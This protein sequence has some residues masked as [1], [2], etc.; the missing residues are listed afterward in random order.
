MSISFRSLF[1][2]H[3]LFI[4]KSLKELYSYINK[5]ITS[6]FS[7]SIYLPST[8]HIYVLKFDITHHMHQVTCR[9]RSMVIALLATVLC[10]FFFPLLLNFSLLQC[11]LLSWVLHEGGEEEEKEKIQRAYYIVLFLSPESRLFIS[12]N[13][14]GNMSIVE[15][16]ESKKCQVISFMWQKVGIKKVRTRLNTPKNVEKLEKVNSC[17]SLFIYLVLRSLNRRQFKSWTRQP[18]FHFVLMIL[19]KT[20]IQLF[21]LQLSVNSRTD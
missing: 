20:R 16:N 9:G 17:F 13:S 18:A 3:C 6:L 12:V 4:Y 1:L 19:G 14:L 5:F 8:V 11:Y 15:R 7:L 21:F 2:C 10:C